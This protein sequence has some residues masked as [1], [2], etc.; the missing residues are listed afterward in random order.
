MGMV[1]NKPE[2]SGGGEGGEGGEG[3]KTR[4]EAETNSAASETVKRPSK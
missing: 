2:R 4:G 1:K 3:T